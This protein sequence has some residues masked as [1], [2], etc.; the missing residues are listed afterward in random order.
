MKR[1]VAV[2]AAIAAV[3]VGAW[4]RPVALPNVPTAEA[5]GI[6][7]AQNGLRLEASNRLTASGAYAR[8]RF[9]GPGDCEISVVPLGSADEILAELSEDS[10]DADWAA[11]VL[12]INH[13][14]P[15]PRTALGVH[16]RLLLARLTDG[17]APQ[18]AMLSGPAAC[19]RAANGTPLTPWP[20]R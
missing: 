9:T 14:G 5:P 20:A 12:L 3:A 4:L 13:L 6:W 11:R 15:M 17:S 8:H 7:A 10:T 2:I 1:S 18:P 16:L 19:L